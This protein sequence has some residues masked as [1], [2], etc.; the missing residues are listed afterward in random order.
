MNL[1]VV[2]LVACNLSTCLTIYY[3]YVEGGELGGFSA[4]VYDLVSIGIGAVATIGVFAPC[5][6]RLVP[7]TCPVGTFDQNLTL[8]VAVDVVGHYH[9][10]L[11]AADVYVRTHI[12]CPHQCSVEIV[13]LDLV[14]SCKRDVFTGLGIV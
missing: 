12:Y 3:R 11:T 1:T 14:S 7:K 13:G 5:L 8:A 4:V 10:V 6:L 9:V 2:Q